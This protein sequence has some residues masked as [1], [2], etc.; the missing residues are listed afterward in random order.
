[1]HKKML[2]MPMIWKHLWLDIG[3]LTHWFLWE[4]KG[5]PTDG[6]RRLKSIKKA[7]QPQN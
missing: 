6:S 7:I 3:M 2:G 4:A 5:L 1:M